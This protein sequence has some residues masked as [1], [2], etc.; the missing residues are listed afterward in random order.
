MTDF[1][2]RQGNTQNTWRIQSL[3]LS[4]MIPVQMTHDGLS[5]LTYVGPEGRTGLIGGCKVH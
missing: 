5:K 4:R 3:R 1:L 2:E